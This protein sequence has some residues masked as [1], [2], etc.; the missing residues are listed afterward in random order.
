MTPINWST[1]I[2]TTNFNEKLHHNQSF[3]CLGSCFAIHVAKHL[4]DHKIKCIVNPLHIAYNPIS[5]VTHIDYIAKSRIFVAEEIQNFNKIFFHDDFHSKY[6]SLSLQ[7]TNKNI[8]NDLLQHENILDKTNTIILTF[9]TAWVYEY[10]ESKKIV[11]NCHK[12]PQIN[13]NK[14]LLTVDEIVRAC[15][16][17]FEKLKEKKIILTVSPIRHLKDGL[18]NNQLSKSILRIAIHQL[19]KTFDH[20]F[21]FPSYEIMMDELRDYRFY[22]SDLLHP[23]EEAI[24]HIFQSFIRSSF[25]DSSL[26]YVE[27]ISSLNKKFGHKPFLADHESYQQFLKNLLK[28]INFLKSQYPQKNFSNEKEVIFSRLN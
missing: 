18:E 1:P 20:V 9:G 17:I 5:L 13:F 24:S 27:R 8:T 4:S 22:T 28:D 11:N 6:N 7:Q 2:K 12:Q 14:R 15:V 23:T 3:L 16:T 10:K 25:D 21:Y 19:Q 26:T